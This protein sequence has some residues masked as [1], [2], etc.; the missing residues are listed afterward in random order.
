M[1]RSFRLLALVLAC[2]LTLVTP[3][4]AAG[5]PS[6]SEEM[7]GVWVSSVYNLDYPS[8]PTTDPDKLRAEADEILDNCVKW[9]LN[10]VFL[11]VR[12][13][14][15]ALYKSDLFPWSKYLT[16]SVG[17]A[18]QD[19]FDPLE[20]WVEA[21]HKR[22]LELHAWINPYRITRGK[23]T[24][25]NQ[26]PSTHP[27]KMNPDWVVKYSDGNYYFNPGLQQVRD[28]VTRGAVEIAQNYDVDGLHMDDYFYPG[29]DLPIPPPT[30]STAAASQT[31]ATGGG[32]T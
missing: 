32:I 11:Q 17:T 27:A 19:G 21:A 14:G 7:R 13:S 28:L 12:P 30:S 26:L 15:D 31:S 22:G 3:A 29:S 24:E 16:G 9:G 20:Y 23:D 6:A 25:W 18:P 4:F 8:S 2:V 5:T 1:K 10:A